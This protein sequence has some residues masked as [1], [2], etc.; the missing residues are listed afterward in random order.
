MK[1]VIVY[2]LIILGNFDIRSLSA[3]MKKYVHIDST[4][5]DMEIWKT[6][7]QNNIKLYYLA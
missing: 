1:A 7:N 5:Y 4:V 6:D 3:R 2:F